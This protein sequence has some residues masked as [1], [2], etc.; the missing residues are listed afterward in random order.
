MV[1][2]VV[3]E[4]KKVKLAL[5]HITV[6]QH[7]ERNVCQDSREANTP[8]DI[9]KQ[10]PEVKE[11][12][13]LVVPVL[14]QKSQ[15]LSRGG[16]ELVKIVVKEQQVWIVS[17]EGGNRLLKAHVAS[18]EVSRIMMEGRSRGQRLNSLAWKG[19]LIDDNGYGYTVD[20]SPER[21]TWMEMLQHMW[22]NPTRQLEPCRRTDPA[23]RLPPIGRPKPASAS[24]GVEKWRPKTMAGKQG[25]KPGTGRRYAL[26]VLQRK[27]GTGRRAD[28]DNAAAKCKCSSVNHGPGVTSQISASALNKPGVAP[29][30][31]TNRRQGARSVQ[32]V[33]GLS[34]KPSL[35]KLAS[36]EEYQQSGKVAQ[37]ER[38]RERGRGSDAATISKM[39]VLR[40]TS[41]E[42]NL[43]PELMQ[44]PPAGSRKDKGFLKYAGTEKTEVLPHAGAWL[45]Q[46]KHRQTDTCLESSIMPD[47][48]PQGLKQELTMSRSIHEDLVKF[49][50]GNMRRKR[51]AHRL[52][53]ID[54]R[55]EGVEHST[56][57]ILFLRTAFSKLDETPCRPEFSCTPGQGWFRV[58]VSRN[59][60]K[61]CWSPFRGLWSLSELQRCKESFSSVRPRVPGDP[62]AWS[63]MPEAHASKGSGSDVQAHFIIYRCNLLKSLPDFPCVTL[64]NSQM[65]PFA[66]LVPG[67]GVSW[68][69]WFAS[70]PTPLGSL[71]PPG[72]H[73][74]S[75]NAARRTGSH[76]EPMPRTFLQGAAR[77]GD[78][79]AMDSTVIRSI[80]RLHLQ[81]THKNE[82]FFSL[83]CSYFITFFQLQPS[84]SLIAHRQPTCHLIF[85]GPIICTSSKISSQWTT[86]AQVDRAAQVLV[87][88]QG[89]ETPAEDSTRAH[90]T[91][92]PQVV[93]DHAKFP[94]AAA[95]TT[96]P[97][98]MV[99]VF[100]R[101]ADPDT[102]DNYKKS[103]R[104]NAN[105]LYKK[106]F[107]G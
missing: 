94:R 47:D 13:C 17:Q 30:F 80:T 1:G 98:N 81:S 29:A 70:S 68:P 73:V 6:C 24:P 26:H 59:D 50:E 107:M 8:A 43:T 9:Q 2:D 58:L 28:C 32:E 100:H 42:E 55:T 4:G 5:N 84:D 99:T 97:A 3:V 34:R 65:V 40:G 22:L 18:E 25:D 46:A 91:S 101:K 106:G 15:K 14:K 54:D 78:I 48:V 16:E 69:I 96:E 76:Q 45:S 92:K 37:R 63:A 31:Q 12:S 53:G 36:L 23:T 93:I 102:T 74:R 104:M 85:L 83:V 86:E 95:A 64:V 62:L 103:A 67:R 49:K 19:P 61:L 57:R 71:D 87:S 90:I 7:T 88:S 52:V 21:S 35:I 77:R 27:P 66:R 51:Y 39:R 20:S 38:E 82:P 75:S 105:R 33:F 79:Q 72:F 56:S 44:G 89:T 11:N 60:K 10:K 41:R